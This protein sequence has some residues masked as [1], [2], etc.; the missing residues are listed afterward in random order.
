MPFFFLQTSEDIQLVCNSIVSEELHKVLWNHVA[1]IFKLKCSYFYISLSCAKF[2]FPFTITVSP[3]ASP[4]YSLLRGVTT[5][6][7]LLSVRI[8]T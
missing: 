8:C 4:S 1:F 6:E 3:A 7:S 5:H 2:R